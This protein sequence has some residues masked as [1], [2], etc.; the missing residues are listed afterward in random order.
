MAECYR[1]RFG[2]CGGVFS[3]LVICRVAAALHA[4]DVPVPRGRRD[5]KGTWRLGQ[6]GRKGKSGPTGPTG[7]QGSLAR[8]VP[9]EIKACGGAESPTGPAGGANGRPR[10]SQG[11]TGG[12]DGTCG[13]ARR[14]GNAWPTGS[15]GPGEGAAWHFRLVH[16]PPG[17]MGAPGPMGPTGQTGAMGSVGPTGASGPT[18][19]GTNRAAGPR[20]QDGA[21]GPAGPQGLSRGNRSHRP[22]RCCAR[23]YLCFLY[24]FVRAFYRWESVAS[25]SVR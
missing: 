9:L 4:Q 20:G 3:R 25:V 23:G 2:P 22:G 24:R 21:T 16:G 18:G 13:A 12:A 15:V 6:R 17:Q 1:C 19:P 11:L 7:P 8:L 5:R 14:K 10:W